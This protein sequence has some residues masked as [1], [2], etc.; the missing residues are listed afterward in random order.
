AVHG[1]C[2]H[3]VPLLLYVHA[4]IPVTIMHNVAYGAF[5]FPFT[6]CQILMDVAAVRV[7]F[8]FG[9]KRSY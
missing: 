2:H 1:Y 4:A 5:P 8:L 9:R 6:E 7:F 3:F